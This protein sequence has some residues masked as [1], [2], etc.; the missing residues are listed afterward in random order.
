MV[1][2]GIEKAINERSD[3]LIGWRCLVVFNVYGYFDVRMTN[4]LREVPHSEWP[5]DIR[6]VVGSEVS[7]HRER[8]FQTR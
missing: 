1:E 4:G 8:Q 2:T 6:E 3:L 5:E 7:R